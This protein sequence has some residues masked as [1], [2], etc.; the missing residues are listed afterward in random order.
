[1]AV[2]Y[3]STMTKSGSCAAGASAAGSALGS[4]VTVEPANEAPTA[5]EPDFI[6]VEE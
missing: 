2:P 6:I 5:D 4:T 1:M 3:S